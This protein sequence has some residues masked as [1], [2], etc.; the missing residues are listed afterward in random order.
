MNLYRIQWQKSPAPD[1]RTTFL[2]VNLLNK[3]LLEYGENKRNYKLRI[4]N[5]VFV[6]IIE[7]LVRN[8]NEFGG[9]KNQ[10]F[11]TGK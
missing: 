3:I 2:G 1:F 10:G 5:T 11:P 7:F 9:G 8:S 4:D 6:R